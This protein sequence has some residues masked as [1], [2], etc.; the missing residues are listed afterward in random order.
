MFISKVN[1]E[2]SKFGVYHFDAIKK[3]LGFV[4]VLENDS[5]RTSE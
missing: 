1:Q 2:D 5:L 4:N 3:K